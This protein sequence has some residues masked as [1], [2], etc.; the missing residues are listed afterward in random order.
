M[1]CWHLAIL[2]DLAPG[3]PSPLIATSVQLGNGSRGSRSYSET[4]PYHCTQF[5]PHRLGCQDLLMACSW[6]S[7]LKWSLDVVTPN[8]WR[9]DQG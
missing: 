3:S 6:T 8:I 1:L 9:G 5:P 4:V 2:I 7:Y